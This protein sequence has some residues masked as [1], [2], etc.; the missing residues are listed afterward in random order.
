MQ[1]PPTLFVFLSMAYLWVNHMTTGLLYKP[2]RHVN[3]VLLWENTFKDTDGAE[4]SVNPYPLEYS[5]RALVQVSIG[6]D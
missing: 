2:A 5:V 1:P 6:G 3:L 4:G